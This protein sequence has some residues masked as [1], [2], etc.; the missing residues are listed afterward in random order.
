MTLKTAPKEK[1]FLKIPQTSGVYFFFGPKSR[2]LYI[3]KAINLRS[4]VRSHFSGDIF[5]PMKSKMIKEAEKIKW[6]ETDSDIEALILEAKLIKEHR[7]FYNVL[8]KDDKSYFFVEIT[9]EG[10]PRIFITHEARKN[11]KNIHIGP[12]TEGGTLKTTLNYLRRVFPY[13]TC[14][15]PHSRTCINAELGKCFD[16]CC[17]KNFNGEDRKKLKREYA[18]NIKNIAAVLSGKKRALVKKLEKEMKT[19]SRQNNY[20]LAAKLRD[21]ISGLENIFKHQPVLVAERKDEVE[22]LKETMG[23]VKNLLG[24]PNLP[25]RI[26][27][28]DISNI[29][30][31]LAVGSMIVFENGRP[32]KKEY[33]KFKIRFKNTPDD[34]AMMKEILSRRLSHHEWRLPDLFVID[35]GRG[36][37]N[38]AKEVLAMAGI[39]TAAVALA[40]REEELYLYGRPTPIRLKELNSGVLYLFQIMRDEAHRFAIGYHKKLRRSLE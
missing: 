24:L 18:K 29:Q 31:K 21:Q 25:Q 13:C 6:Q 17:N 26:E 28:Y 12:F 8:M 27:T 11:P 4:R 37:L 1:D 9:S 2:L 30:G 20:E 34:T 10:F 22:Q 38:A 23:N 32:N 35:G 19:A 16:F 3:G 15:K 40:K 5:I 39:R 33:R 14:P 7:P 36:Q